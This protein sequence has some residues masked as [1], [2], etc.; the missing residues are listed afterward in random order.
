MSI[1]QLTFNSLSDILFITIF[2]GF[3]TIPTMWLFLTLITPKTIL[4][5]YFR[6]P[7]FTDSEL[8]IMGSFPSSLLRTSIFSWVTVFPSLGRK[9]KIS[10]IRINTPLWYKALIIL[11]I[12]VVIPSA[13]IIFGGIPFL[14]SVNIIK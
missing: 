8:E 9:R 2:F 4:E 5:N 13:I 12:S 10:D 7:H 3:F 14:L 6:Y 11:W 1:T